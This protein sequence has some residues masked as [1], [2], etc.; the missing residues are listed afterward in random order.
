MILQKTLLIS[1]NIALFFSIRYQY[2]NICPDGISSVLIGKYFDNLDYW[3][4]AFP[5][6]FLLYIQLFVFI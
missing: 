6:C 2:K 4:I 3:Y 5:V 1:L